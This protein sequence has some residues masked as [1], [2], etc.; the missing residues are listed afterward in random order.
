[1]ADAEETALL[2]PVPAAD[3]RIGSWRNRLDPAARRGVPSHVTILYPFLP[4]TAL[5]AA[6][7]ASLVDVFADVAAFDFT[8]TRTAW[9]GESVFWLAPE[10]AAPFRELTA[11]VVARWPQCPPYAGR[12][13]EVVPHLTI[14]DGAPP[15]EL[16]IAERQVSRTMPIAARAAEILLMSGTPDA[17]SWTTL[18][19]FALKS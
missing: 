7:L 3:A 6:T 19:R 12:F 17:A 11:R 9:F 2:V 15:D 10:P 18:A 14:G 1:M 5:D 4:P 8:L 13:A 16:R